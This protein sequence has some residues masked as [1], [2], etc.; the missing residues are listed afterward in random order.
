M[1][2]ARATIFQIAV[3]LAI[4]LLILAAT[5]SVWRSWL[6][7]QQL[8]EAILLGNVEKV[9]LLLFLRADNSWVN[10]LDPK[11]DGRTYLGMAIGHGKPRPVEALLLA[12]ADPRHQPNGESL[13]EEARAM[14][15]PPFGRGYDQTDVEEVLRLIE[16]AT[17]G[18]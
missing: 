9:R 3:C 14:A 18:R 7:R 10:G 16:S 8:H 17:Q 12:G 2:G 6:S 15:T 5:W 4:A 11:G 1:N 13:L